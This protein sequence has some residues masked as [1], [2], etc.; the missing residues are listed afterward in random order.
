MGLRETLQKATSAM[1]D[2]L[3]DIPLSVTVDHYVTA[4]YDI[5]AGQNVASTEAYMTSG[6]FSAF[7]AMETDFPPLSIDLRTDVRLLIPQN[8]LSCV[9]TNLDSVRYVQDG[10]SVTAD[11]KNVRRDPA[12]AT[13]VLHLRK[14]G[15]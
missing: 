8:D 13:W 14:R 12:D 15:A 9:P 2:A 5:S 11:V 6:V 3:G 7:K 1:F 4:A 10:T